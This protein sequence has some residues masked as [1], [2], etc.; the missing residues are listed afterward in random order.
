MEHASEL[1]R[2]ENCAFLRVCP[3]SPDNATAYAFYHSL[4]FRAAPIHMH[5]EL[6]WMLD[7]SKSEEQLLK[8]MRKT[9]RYLIKKLDAEGVEIEMSVEAAD[10][11]KFWPVYEQTAKRQH[12][13]PFS[14]KDL[15]KEFEIFSEGD[16][17]PGQGALF[18]FGKHEGDIVAAAII[19]FYNGQAFYHHSGSLSEASGSNVSYL[20]QWRV[21][22]EARRRGCTLYNF[23]GISPENQP[24][25]PWAGLSQFKKGFGG[26]AEHYLHAQDKALS[27]KY[28]INWIVETTRR[29]KRGF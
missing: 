10:I 16:S 25:H 22:Q 15:Q 12:F 11:E 9:T 14:K 20:L 27:W 19:V 3:L 1:A 24:K 17:L 18:F 29:I 2:K 7:I 26:F 23:W 13:T 21:I 8:E 4:G 5:P 28:W 6:A